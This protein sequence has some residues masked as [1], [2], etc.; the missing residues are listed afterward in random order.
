MSALGLVA[1]GRMLS[2]GLERCELWMWGMQGASRLLGELLVR[3]WVG[4]VNGRL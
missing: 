4:R 2:R 1:G 3:R